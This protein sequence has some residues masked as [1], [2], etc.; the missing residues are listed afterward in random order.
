MTRSQSELQSLPAWIDR[1]GDWNPQ[2]LRELK[3]RLQ[4]RSV[5]L[6]VALVAILQVLFMMSFAQR[7][8][9]QPDVYS[10]YCVNGN[11]QMNGILC[12]TDWARWWRDI[13]NTLN[14]AIAF[15]V[16]LSG[17]YF[18]TTDINQEEQ[19][20][21]M[22]FLRLSPR[23][24]QTILLGKLLGVPSLSYLILILFIP[25]HL[26]VGIMMKIP[27]SFFM[28]YYGS[29]LLYGAV[30]LMTSL[31]IGFSGRNG[32]MKGSSTA[33]SGGVLLSI[34]LILVLIPTCWSWNFLTIWNPYQLLLSDSLSPNNVYWF[35]QLI[36]QNA[37]VSH[38][39]TW[40]NLA[41]VIALLWRILQRAFQNP[42]ATLLSKRQSYFLVPY[43]LL[44]LLGLAF[45]RSSDN[46][47][48]SLVLI[49]VLIPWGFIGLLFV[50][51]TPRQ[52]WLDWFR[53][54]QA[55][56]QSQEISQEISQQPYQLNNARSTNDLIWGDKSPGLTAIGL[57]LLLVTGI[58][59]TALIFMPSEIK[60]GPNSRD[61]S[62]DIEI[63]WCS[64]LLTVTLVTNYA[65]LVQWML[66]LKTQ[67]RSAWALG[68]VV[69]T[70]GLSSIL[71]S[72][73]LAIDYKSG[74]GNMLLLCSPWFRMALGS[75]SGSS[76]LNIT[77]ALVIQT[78]GI[79]FLA[80]RVQSEC[81][82]MSRATRSSMP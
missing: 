10:Y 19:R 18:L 67:K 42:K 27:L 26:F 36:T 41:I 73:F 24:S 34:L 62:G 56:M 74:I 20:G 60:F 1:L 23:S 2:L 13:F 61:I 79:L 75:S 72:L 45:G 39:F 28:S 17:V 66:L 68:S 14:W 5:L 30:F 37:I 57:N 82:S 12:K 80:S 48:P 52:T 38:L 81:R 69:L 16:Y 64:I 49:Q 22:N 59:V 78:I 50:L 43:S 4:W 3:G 47:I 76:F 15:L 11:F 33:V 63:A 21:T 25:F 54:R 44:C 70:V 55:A 31:L 6:T 29:F 46:P 7:L 53:Y 32:S 65:L 35:R 40:G 9:S 71:G 51:S 77:G 8:P 58:M